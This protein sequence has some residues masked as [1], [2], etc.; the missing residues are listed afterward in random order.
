[1]SRPFH[2][3]CC[4]AVALS[5]QLPTSAREADFP[6]LTISATVEEKKDAPTGDMV[7]TILG[8]GTAAYPEGTSL[9]FKARLKGASGYLDKQHSVRV[10]A[11]GR[12][13]AAIDE[14]GRN[15]YKGLYEACVTFDSQN[16]QDS[17]LKAIRAKKQ[18][19]GIQSQSTEIQLGTAEEE[20]REKADIEQVYA[21][22]F[23][24]ARGICER[25]FAQFEAQKKEPNK[26]AWGD[27][28]DD[29][30]E[31]L[32]RLDSG[33]SEFRRSRDNMRDP[34]TYDVISNIIVSVG[35]GWFYPALSASL[36]FSGKGTT[37]EKENAQKIL[38]GL[39]D[40]LAAL[41]KTIGQVKIDPN[42]KPAEP[43]P[44]RKH[45]LP[46]PVPP[47]D[48][49]GATAPPPVA[50]PRPPGTSLVPKSRF[51]IAELG[52]GLAALCGLAMLVVLLK[53]K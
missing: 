2:A 26:L 3:A 52:I 47:L 44:I 33:L 4:L 30:S 12:W 16:Q 22:A 15:V 53:R 43:V 19:T 21:R 17:I 50:G 45:I 41:D 36:G 9:V 10:D 38:Q 32:V 18:N 6:A 31:E 40:K 46:R 28:V 35:G 49:I 42:W 37:A 5:L 8:S 1:M 24:S 48:P 11:Q 23:D 51:G 14:L 27:F 7:R 29:I 34:A 13:E 39:K 25:T 20:L